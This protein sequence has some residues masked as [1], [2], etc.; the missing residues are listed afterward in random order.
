MGRCLKSGSSALPTKTPT[1]RGPA[2]RGQGPPHPPPR[3]RSIARGSHGTDDADLDWRTLENPT[4]SV[5]PYPLRRV[6]LLP[7]R[8]AV[9]P[10]VIPPGA[11]GRKSSRHVRAAGTPLLNAPTWTAWLG[12]FQHR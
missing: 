2:N 6:F 10:P 5:W 12:C 8:E 1:Q 7:A 3:P 11:P 4:P 9:T